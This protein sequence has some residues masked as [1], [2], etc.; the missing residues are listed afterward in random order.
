[1]FYVGEGERAVNSKLH[2]KGLSIRILIC[3]EDI[4]YIY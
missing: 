4:F 3:F 2:F 1:V